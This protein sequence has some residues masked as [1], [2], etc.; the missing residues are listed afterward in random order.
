MR[1]CQGV[2]SDKE[3]SPCKT[4][5]EPRP[6]VKIELGTYGDSY[7]FGTPAMTRLNIEH[8]RGILLSITD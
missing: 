7:D 2:K 8:R 5:P 1:L 6:S 3:Q 4:P